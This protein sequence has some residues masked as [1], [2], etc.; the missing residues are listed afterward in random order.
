MKDIFFVKMM[1]ADGELTSS[2]EKVEVLKETEKTY[3]VK[4]AGSGKVIVNKS[5]LNLFKEST[6]RDTHRT[7]SREG[8]IEEDKV[9]ETS[10]QFLRSAT[11]HFKKIQEL[12]I[13]SLNT[14]SKA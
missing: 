1:V 2:K 5:K 11:T 14:I 13:K 3:T 6:Y 4:P 9:N 10:K 12:A 8:Y 7:F